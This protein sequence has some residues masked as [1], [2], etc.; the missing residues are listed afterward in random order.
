MSDFNYSL[1]E[2]KKLIKKNGFYKTIKSIFGESAIFAVDSGFLEACASLQLE[3]L[4]LSVRAYNCMKRSR[5]NTVG[6]LFKPDPK[7][8]LGVDRCLSRKSLDEFFE[9]FTEFR[10]QRLDETDKN[11]IIERTIELNQNEERRKENEIMIQ[12]NK[13]IV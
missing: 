4:D 11:N 10:F 12:S 13:A 1:E 6:D 3:D 7:S 5:I 2:M 8:I 9:K